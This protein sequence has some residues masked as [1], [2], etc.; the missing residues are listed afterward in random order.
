MR[1]N[2]FRK[3]IENEYE[4]HDLLMNLVK[5]KINFKLTH[6]LQVMSQ[7]S[8]AWDDIKGPK[9]HLLMICF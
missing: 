6:D 4:M 1:L 3:K 2:H 5:G 9:S 7:K 8:L